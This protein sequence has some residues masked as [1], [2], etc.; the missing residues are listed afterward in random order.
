MI[1]RTPP[2]PA[3]TCTFPR[4]AVGATALATREL[5]QIL[6]TLTAVLVGSELNVGSCRRRETHLVASWEVTR[7]A[8]EPMPVWLLPAPPDGALVAAMSDTDDWNI[9]VCILA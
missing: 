9:G 7:R 6:F 3:T 2:F 4:I 1:W 8:S 5:A